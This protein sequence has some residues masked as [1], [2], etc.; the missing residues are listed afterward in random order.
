MGAACALILGALLAACGG[1]KR[2]APGSGQ[3][4]PDSAGTTAGTRLCDAHGDTVLLSPPLNHVI[5]LAPNIT[6]TIFA[7]GAGD[8][9]VGRT[10]YC[11]YPAQ[12]ASV[13]V[14]ADLLTLNYE[15]I[16]AV[17]P[18]LVFMTFAGNT[19]GNYEKLK[20]LGVRPFALKDGSIADIAGAIDTVGSLL[21]HAEQGRA[22]A[23]QLRRTADSISTL[24]AAARKASVFMVI[25]RAPLM[26]VS[27][28]FINELITVAGGRNIAAGGLIAY[29]KFSREALLRENPDVIIVPG[30]SW[31]AV[32]ALLE[33]YPEWRQLNAF[34]KNRIYVLPSDV[35]LRPGPRVGES[36]KLFYAALHDAD[37]KSLMPAR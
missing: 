26:T 15:K 31:E 11:D 13:P 35:I 34:K 14:V 27:N 12:A 33:A 22:L 32:D 3:T 19:E 6:E 37:P 36:L 20:E 28:G 1:D 5:S 25:D 30:T 9:L 29:P 16:V 8:R 10:S 7:V 21:G 18:D 2:P 24:A 4:R 23:A 17:R